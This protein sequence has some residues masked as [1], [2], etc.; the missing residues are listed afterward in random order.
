MNKNIKLALIGVL[1][2]G[3]SI[4]NLNLSETIVTNENVHD[5]NI[6]NHL[7]SSGF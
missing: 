5:N 3:L 1:L 2:F 7:T 4:F 6:I